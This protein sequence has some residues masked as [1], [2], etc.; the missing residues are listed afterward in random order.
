MLQG[1]L[2][3]GKRSDLRFL[4]GAKRSATSSSKDFIKS[5][6]S[7]AC[8]LFLGFLGNTG[9]PSSLVGFSAPIK[10]ILH[11]DKNKL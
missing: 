9:D 5:I 10:H 11:H 1:S 2:F 4:V 7:S 8:F 3:A 6:S